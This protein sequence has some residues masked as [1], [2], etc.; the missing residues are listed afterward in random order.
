MKSI[1]IC[2]TAC[3][4]DTT[5]DRNTYVPSILNLLDAE[6]IENAAEYE[7]TGSRR[8]LP[9]DSVAPALIGRLLEV[10]QWVHERLAGDFSPTPEETVAVNKG[11]HGVRPV[12]I[13]DLPSRIAYRALA[14]SLLDKLPSF[15]RGRSE[16][17]EFLAEPL[18]RKG[19]YIVASDI[20]AC[21]Q[22]IDHGLLSDELLVQ[23]GEF[24]TVSAIMQLLHDVTGKTYGLPQQNYASDWLSEPFLARLERSLIR[25]GLDV[26]RYNDDFR[27]VC[28]DWA[29]VVRAI[30]VLEEEARRVGLTIN[31]QKTITWSRGKFEEYIKYARELRAD[32]T[33][34]EDPEVDS[35]Y[36][37]EEDEEEESPAFDSY[38]ASDILDR[39]VS[40]AGRGRVAPRRRAEHRVIVELIPAALRG[41]AKE[42]VFNS[43]ILR[44]CMK[45]LRFE[46]TVTPYVGK[47]FLKFSREDQL[48]DEF[49]KLLRSRSYLNGWQTWWLQQP[50]ARL[51][52]FA[53]GPGSTRR[54]RWART[55]LSTT[56]HSP[57]LQAEAARTLARHGQIDLNELLSMYD[58]SGNI[59]Q[60]VLTSAIALLRPGAHIRRAVIGDSKIHQWIYEWASR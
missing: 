34:E 44:D 49:D 47:Y 33:G 40:V 10:V 25:R 37:D 13:W 22:Q 41:L 57:V 29:G 14:W 11:R 50:V 56:E 12:A 38:I 43:D 20:A 9:A 28:A 51:A 18:Q 30:E 15:Q 21:Y 4:S 24:E 36:V 39:W 42:A 55:A 35:D 7:L 32:I 2:I 60:P 16:W 19:R 45:L 59:V 1:K 27:F 54:V 3:Q 31:D 53:T 6:D 52:G 26:S 17:Q 46:R 48:L 8:A 23:T 58:R 5:C